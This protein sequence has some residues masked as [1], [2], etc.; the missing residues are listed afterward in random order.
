MTDE[1]E[2]ARVIF[3]KILDGH[4]VRKHYSFDQFAGRKA[5][6]YLA[7]DGKFTDFQKLMIKVTVQNK[8]FL[9]AARDTLKEAQDMIDSGVD[10]EIDDLGIFY[11]EKGLNSRQLGDND[12]AKQYFMKCFALEDQELKREFYVL[13]HSYAE[14]AEILLEE[15][16]LKS[17]KKFFVKARKGYTNYDFDKPLVR[18]LEK[19]LDDIKKGRALEKA[20]QKADQRKNLNSRYTKKQGR[21]TT[22]DK[23]SDD[24]ETTHSSASGGTREV[25]SLSTPPHFI[26]PIDLDEPLEGKVIEVPPVQSPEESESDEFFSADEGSDVDVDDVTIENIHQPDTNAIEVAMNKLIDDIHTDD[27]STTESTLPRPLEKDEELST[28]YK[29]QQE[30]DKQLDQLVMQMLGSQL[31]DIREHTLRLRSH[32]SCFYGINMVMALVDELGLSQKE[33]LETGQLLLSNHRIR[34]VAHSSGFKAEKLLYRFQEHV[35]STALNMS[36]LW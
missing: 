21:S 34:E 20:K 30:L 12:E 14:C 13:P 29:K 5:K 10:I 31:L 1:N 26:K 35:K 6:E 3:K 24:A 28:E 27:Y 4:W 17:A 19:W 36:K 32:A 8:A 15:G 25:L 2:K 22:L 16:D 11:Y 7:S 33:A 23:G 18:R 9:F